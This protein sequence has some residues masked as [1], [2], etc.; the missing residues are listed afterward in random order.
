MVKSIESNIM[1]KISNGEDLHTEFK[2]AE[3]AFPKDGLESVSAFA[4]TDGGDLILGISESKTEDGGFF[5]TGIKNPR[6][7]ID[8]F[9]TKMNNPQK[10]SKN[11]VSN[12][13]VS[14]IPVKSYL[15]E[16]TY[17][18]VIR[19][20]AQDYRNKP[21]YLNNNPKLTYV[22]LGSADIQA[23]DDII[24]LMIRD[25]SRESTDSF[26][27]L[28]YSISDLDEATISKYRLNFKSIHPEHPFNSLDD[29]SFL[30]KLNALR[31]DRKTG[32]IVPTVAGLLVFGKHTS[33][34]EYL[35]WYNVEYINKSKTGQNSSYV[36]RVIY[37][38]AW[39]EDNLYNFF[40]EVINKLYLTINESSF[41]AD[42]DITRVSP[43]KLRIALREAL[44]NS[45]I[46]CDFKAESEC[47][48]I[49]RYADRIIFRNGGN[50]RISPNDFF[51]GGV[52]DPRNYLIQEIFRLIN[53]CEKAGTGIPKIMDA[54]KTY[55]FKKPEIL[56]KFDSF[57]ITIW[58][59]SV[60]DT[61]PSLN[62]TEKSILEIIITKN[63][64]TINEIAEDLGIHRNTAAKYLNALAKKHILIKH[65]L[66]KEYNF[67]FE[68]GGDFTKYNIL[69]SFYTFLEEIKRNQK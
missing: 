53:L 11:I 8:D 64:V 24:N 46:H 65:K 50:L 35:P 34:K 44:V 52:S 6:H 12:D 25:A 42:D 2:K 5:I 54:V 40:N 10:I 68:D 23:R 55:K 49:I 41:I 21:I 66:G 45:I 58:D 3:N 18:V 14:T 67:M 63:I 57:E 43:S 22:R 69:D 31:T 16:D 29:E 61:L 20:Y 38:G 37:D 33:I 56:N 15:G 48:Y 13:D 51:S 1:N 7:V 62:A 32:D 27:L 4:N 36:D 39:G 47:I 17:I 26:N 19:I 59:T 28:N 60:I 9:F 30:K